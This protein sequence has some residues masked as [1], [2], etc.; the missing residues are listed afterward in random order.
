MKNIL[1]QPWLTFK[2][3]KIKFDRMPA[4]LYK[5]VAYDECIESTTVARTAA[6]Q[7]CGGR[8]LA[9]FKWIYQTPLS[10]RRWGLLFWKTGII[11]LTAVTNRQNT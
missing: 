2:P 10:V 5:Y 4:D 11:P 1:A 9:R 3:V 6:Y 8:V 7:P